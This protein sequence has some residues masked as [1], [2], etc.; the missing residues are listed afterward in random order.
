M[1]YRIQ[2]ILHGI[3]LGKAQVLT[4]VIPFFAGLIILAALY[5]LG[6]FSVPPF[7]SIGGIFRGLDDP[8]SMD[9]AQLARQIMRG[10]GFTTKFIRPYALIQLRD[11][12][13]TQGLDTGQ[14]GQLFPP[15]RFPKG[16]QRI[17]PDTYNAPGY[18]CLLLS[19]RRLVRLGQTPV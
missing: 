6:P 18:P 8:Q 15:D 13:I 2:T 5:D 1:I 17:I 19:P 16:T 11:Y 10:Q 14:L 12:A 9:N 4:R 7:L 3:E